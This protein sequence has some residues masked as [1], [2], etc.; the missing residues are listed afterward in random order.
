MSK[1]ALEKQ[2]YATAVEEIRTYFLNERDEEIGELQ[3]R[4]ILNFF[5]EKIGPHVYNQAIFDMQKYMSERVEDMAGFM[6]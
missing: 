1:I 5:L 3:G 2:E 6:R 4:L